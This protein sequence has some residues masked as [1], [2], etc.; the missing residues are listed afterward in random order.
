M[1][2]PDPARQQR[3]EKLQIKLTSLINDSNVNS[4]GLSDWHLRLACH[5]LQRLAFIAGQSRDSL[6]DLLG[7]SY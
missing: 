6:F 3:S 1:L 2:L 7:A 5:V 4:T